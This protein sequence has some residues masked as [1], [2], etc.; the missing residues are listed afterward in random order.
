MGT[1]A[2]L[3]QRARVLYDRHV[4]FVDFSKFGEAPPLDI[5]TSTCRRVVHPLLTVVHPLPYR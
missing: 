5:S 4:L 2:R 1:V 3:A